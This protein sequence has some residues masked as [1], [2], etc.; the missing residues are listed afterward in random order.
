MK[1]TNIA[2]AG[3]VDALGV[4][5]YTAIVAYIMLNAPQA[6]GNMRDVWGPIAFLMLFV[7]S[8]TVVG[9]LVFGR[10][11]YV[12]FEGKKKEAVELFIFTLCFL[13]LATFGMLIGMSL[14]AA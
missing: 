9:S 14:Y 3:L 7:L 12:Y 6:F 1:K 5:A 10:P 4:V 13:T 8:A 2:L 11:V